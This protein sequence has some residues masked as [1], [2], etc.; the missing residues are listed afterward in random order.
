M[1]GKAEEMPSIVHEFVHIFAADKRRGALFRADKVDPN[2]RISPEKIAQ[3]ARSRRGI[4]VTGRVGAK[5][6]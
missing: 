2:N 3:G 1:A 4:A 5:V 6:A